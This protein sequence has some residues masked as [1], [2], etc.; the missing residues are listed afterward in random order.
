MKV[1]NK[2]FVITGG[3]SGLGQAT[4]ELL[5][6]CGARVSVVGQ[7][8]LFY[9]LCCWIETKNVGKNLLQN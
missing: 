9:R 4:A 3:A 1:D 5:V 8:L 7:N 2:T 6:Q